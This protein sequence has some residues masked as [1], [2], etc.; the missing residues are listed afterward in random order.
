MKKN[1][2]SKTELFANVPVRKAL[3]AM[4]L[5]TI[6]SQLINLIYNMVDAFFIGRTGNSYMMAAASLTLPLVLMNVVLG[7]LFGIGGGSLVARLMGKEENERAREV[8]AFSLYAAITSAV[9]FAGLIGVFL[10]PVLRFLGASDATIGYTRSYAFLVVVCGCLPALLS[11]ILAHL[12]RNTGYSGTASFGLSMGGILNVLLD[13]LWMFVIMPRGKEVTGAAAA[14]LIS[15][16][17]ACVYL[18]IAYRRAWAA[19]PLSM[20]AAKALRIGGQERRELFAVGVP[21]ALLTGLFDVANIYLNMRAAA[22]S[23][24]VVAAMGT[25]VRVERLPNAVNVGICQGMLPI[26]AFNYT[27]GNHARMRETIRTA[28]NAGLLVAAFS[29]VLF[30]LFAGPIARIFL[31]TSAGDT[32]SALTTVALMTLFLRIRATAAPVQMLNYHSSFCMQAMGDGR[33]TLLHSFVREIVF[34]MPFMALFDVLFGETGL[35]WA[36]PAGEGCGAVL[37]LLLLRRFLRKNTEKI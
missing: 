12:L 24:L 15:N 30:E 9:I 36:L 7:N 6:I 22:H 3:W 2:I 16:C 23:D 13:P 5:P 25:V 32:Q 14:T 35:A 17:I 29:I 4:A 11:M 37:A 31:D 8:S 20:S 1:A 33:D 10:D 19:A 27:S 28:R 26:V 34:Y 18:L 21:S